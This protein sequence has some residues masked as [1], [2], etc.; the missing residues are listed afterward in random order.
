MN[1]GT[2]MRIMKP[3]LRYVQYSNEKFLNE[4]LKCLTEINVAK[5][6]G[7][8]FYFEK[9]YTSKIINNHANIPPAILQVAK[10]DEFIPEIYI[11]YSSFFDKRINKSRITEL[12]EKLSSTLAEDSAFSDSE[13]AELFSISDNKQFLFSLMMKTLFVDNNTSS[14]SGIVVWENGNSYIQA[15]YGDI[16]KYAFSNR[17][18]R[19]NI[20]VIPVN[21]RY[22][23]HLSTKL[24]KMVDPMISS[25]TIHGEWLLRLEKQA[26]RIDDIPKRIQDDL[27]YRG[28]EHNQDG[29]Y[30]IGT[31]AT[32]DIGNTCFYLLA[33]STFDKRNHASSNPDFIKQAIENLLDF[34][35]ING[36]GYELYVPL[37]GTG[38]SRAGMSFQESFDLIK[39]QAIHRAL[40]FH[41]K[42]SIVISNDLKNEIYIGGK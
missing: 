31:I 7:E 21:T 10:Q 24:E 22:D 26:G 34:Y 32:I 42:I 18:K 40:S 5:N 25:E 27:T 9:T 35:D 39:T 12:R 28:I 20:V 29:E 41:G 16:F 17:R 13:K 8:V 30:P 11:E 36:Q 37:L 6:N 19:K 3:F 14:C 15:V 33:I 2:L 23:M 1:L 38:R 4:M